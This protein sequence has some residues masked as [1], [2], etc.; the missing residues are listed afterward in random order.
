MKDKITKTCKQ[1]GL[2]NTYPGIKFDKDNTCN[3]CVYFELNK[4]REKLSRMRM[5]KEFVNVV[6]AA[7]SRKNKYDC[8][9]AYSGGKDSSFLLYFL[10]RRFNLKILAHTF[11]NGFVSETAQKNIKQ[12]TKVLGIDHQTTRPGFDFLQGLFISALKEEFVFPKEILAMMSPVCAACLGMV[13][14][15]TINRAIRLRIP[16]MFI[17]FTPGQYPAISL[18]NFFKV[19]SCVYLSDKVYRDDPWDVLKIIS[20]PIREKFGRQASRYFFKSQYVAKRAFIPKVLFPFHVLLDYD[21]KKIIEAISKIGWVKPKDTDS[22]STNCLLNSLGNFCFAK[23]Y[24]YHPYAGE[25]AYL[26][27]TGKLNRKQVLAAVKIEDDSFALKHSLRKL[28]IKCD[29]VLKTESCLK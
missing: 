1:C 28:N 10:K 29:D 13:F 2:P 4:N 21:E 27:R 11:D 19:K 8:V 17:G 3:Y 25:L 6:N 12:V 14:G 24:G 7:K 16:V 9:V 15:S 20:D 23:K 5:K 26:A 18:E 22:C